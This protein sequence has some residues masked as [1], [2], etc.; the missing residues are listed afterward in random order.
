MKTDSSGSRPRWAANPVLFSVWCVVAAF[1]TYA[2]M[3]GFRK[4]F[5]AATFGDW[6]EGA[7]ALLVTTQ[8]VGYMLSK[9]IGIKVVS[10]MRPER[11]AVVLLGLIGVALLA[12]LGFAVVPYPFN[13][14]CLFLN[15]LPL[16]MVYGLVLGFLE[17]RR[18]TEAFVAGLCASFILADGVAKSVGKWLLNTGVS[19]A[20][21]PATAGLIFLLPLIGFVWMLARI[22]AP[23]GADVAERAERTPMTGAERWAML[24]RHG[25]GL[26]LILVSFLLVT[27]LRSLRSDFAPELWKAL[28]VSGAPA[29]FTVSEMWVALGVTIAT[30]LLSLVRNNR[31][32]F[33]GGL[34]LALAGFGLT[35]VAVAAQGAGRMGAFPF[36]VLVG[37]G[38]YLP[39]VV[40]HTT[41]FE[42]LIAMTRERGNM[43][44]LMYV[45]DSLGYLGYAGLLL[46]K[47]ATGGAGN[48]ETFRTAI[49]LVGGLSVAALAGAWI[50]YRRRVPVVVPLRAAGA[51]A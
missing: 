48:L 47:S 25:L 29:L 45:A 14:V 24:R 42:R 44:Y 23:E 3:Y 11:R 30:G 32:A 28:G 50:S 9:F 51:S 8:L 34:V 35:L 38:L 13:A 31:R 20:W 27:V 26:G 18:M 39:Y 21:M 40:V 17:G 2:C 7:K 5:T 49:W 46:W 12:L 1:G 33:F 19:D 4:P 15:G 16:G 10:E 36:M 6:G 37:L 41:L 22:P 43:G